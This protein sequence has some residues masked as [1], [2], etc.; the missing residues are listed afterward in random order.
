MDGPV[1]LGDGTAEQGQLDP[2]L[3]LFERLRQ[4]T[5]Y[6]WDE[7]KE[8]FHSSYDNWYV[9]IQKGSASEETLKGE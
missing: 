4:L 7:E 6:A 1:A 3:R 5:G 2:P 8:P 9:R